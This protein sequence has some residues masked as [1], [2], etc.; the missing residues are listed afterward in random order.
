VAATV[1]IGPAF[2][3]FNYGIDKINQSTF[4][5]RPYFNG[6]ISAGINSERFFAGVT[7]SYQTLEVDYEN[8]NFTNRNGTLRI[9]AGYRFREVGILKKRAS[10]FMKHKS[11]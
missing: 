6:R 10:E 8:I 11:R 1:A 9:A 3:T 4:D 7:Y 2:Q 5:I